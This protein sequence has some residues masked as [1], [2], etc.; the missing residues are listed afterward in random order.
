MM[1]KTRRDFTPEFKRE[2]V[3]LLEASSPPLMQI[4]TELGIS[5][6]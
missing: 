3:A 5:P 1:T 6:P 4:A 2:A